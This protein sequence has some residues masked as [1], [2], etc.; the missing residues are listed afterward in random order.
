MIR[1]RQHGLRHIRMF[2]S[3]LNPVK[4]VRIGIGIFFIYIDTSFFYVAWSDRTKCSS[5]GHWLWLDLH[6][7]LQQGGPMQVDGLI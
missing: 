6:F 3:N 1:I 5:G 2:L 4:D 7:R